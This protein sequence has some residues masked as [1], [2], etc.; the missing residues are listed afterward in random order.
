MSSYELLYRSNAGISAAAFADENAAT[1][2]VV[3]NAISVFGLRELTGGA[4]AYVNFTRDLIMTNLAYMARPDQMIVEVPGGMSIDDRL[5]DRLYE[6]K[7]MGYR[8][9]LGG[10]TQR[11]AQLKFN[12]IVHLFDFVRL[13][14][15][16]HN[17]LQ[18]R[19]LVS[20]IRR[21]SAADLIMEQVESEADYD[22]VKDMDFLL[23]QGYFFERPSS[24]TKKIDLEESSYG[25]LFNECVRPDF[26]FEICGA[27]IE[28]DPMLTHMLLGSTPRPN[29]NRLRR[30]QDIQRAM[31]PMGTNGM[32][33]WIC[34]VLLKN[35][36]VGES[37]ALPHKAYTRGEFLS[38][39]IEASATDLSAYNG[40]L[41][42]VFSLLDE[43]MGISKE[44]LLSAFHVPEGLKA[45]LM[46][47]KNEYFEFL[48][49]A[50][51]YE[52]T[53][54]FPDDAKIRTQ[55]SAAKL[56]MLYEE[57]EKSTDRAWDTINPFIKFY[58]GNILR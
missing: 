48:R 56:N 9:S 53:Y 21:R 25:R 23:W 30:M 58:T 35:I 8:L 47:E 37:D 4:P 3:S 14:V 31:M 26:D 18:L 24:I 16:L 19:D 1:R 34:L 6:L 42:G 40:F 12:N 7:N 27:L 10:Y 32:R 33:K 52:K 46:G 22:K 13:N 50:R 51:T 29:T 45:A 28:G 36:N 15:R 44:E 38:R 17:R 39:V 5:T 2:T 49:C 20:N 54:R 57:C 41:L 43:I 11:N 55:L